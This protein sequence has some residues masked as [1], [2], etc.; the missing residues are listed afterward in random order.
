MPRPYVPFF[1]EPAEDGALKTAYTCPKKG[2]VV[3]RK[4]SYKLR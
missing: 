4:L 3:Q 2:R 1:N